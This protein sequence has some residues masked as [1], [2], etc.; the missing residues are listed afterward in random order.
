MK[1]GK[2]KK[3]VKR[4]YWYCIHAAVANGFT[5]VHYVRRADLIN[6]VMVRYMHPGTGLTATFLYTQSDMPLKKMEKLV[7]KANTKCGG[8]TGARVFG[9]TGMLIETPRVQKVVTE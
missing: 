8:R 3:R 5:I 7:K 2:L 9:R 6:T 1:L 4:S